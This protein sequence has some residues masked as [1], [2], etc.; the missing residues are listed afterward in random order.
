[1]RP[2]MTPGVTGCL[3]GCMWPQGV[4]G[5]LG[6]SGV[7]LEVTDGLVG[8]QMASG[9][10]GGLVGSWVAMGGRSCPLV[11]A[12]DPIGVSGDN[13]FMSNIYKCPKL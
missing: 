9:A 11:V 1:M 6:G 2:R 13:N 12:V 8:L 5:S 3:A 7:A 10:G 4:A